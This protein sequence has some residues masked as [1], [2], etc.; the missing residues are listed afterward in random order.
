MDY[1]GKNEDMLMLFFVLM[2]L[3]FMGLAIYTV[4][5]YIQEL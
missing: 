5:I 1:N 2:G 3:V 4:V